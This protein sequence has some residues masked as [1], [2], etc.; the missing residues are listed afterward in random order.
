VIIQFKYLSPVSTYCWNCTDIT[1]RDI[2]FTT[3][4]QHHTYNFYKTGK[5]QTQYK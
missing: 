2:A 1:I 5:D 3:G 4:F